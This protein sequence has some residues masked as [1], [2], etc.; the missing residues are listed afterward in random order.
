MTKKIDKEVKLNL[1]IENARIYFRNF[2]GKEGKFN[3]AG[4]R[5]F[6][7]FIDTPKAKEL[8]DDG[9]NIKWLMPRDPDE[10]KQAYLQVT[11]SFAKLPPKIVTIT[12]NGKT[13]IDE[14]TVNILDWA[15]ISNADMII[16]PYNYDVNGKRGVKAYLKTAYFTLAEDALE[17]KYQNVPD[18]A[19]AHLVDEEDEV[20][21]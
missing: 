16:R 19:M 9:W 10:D 12:A 5:N 18:S 11:V 4:R 2:S 7:V 6:C 1:T 3:P 13:L 15:E 17:Q 21:F 20:P 14:S 8:Q